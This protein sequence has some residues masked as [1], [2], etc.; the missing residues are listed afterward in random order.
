MLILS[1][2][3]CLVAPPVNRAPGVEINVQSLKDHLPTRYLSRL[4]EI[5]AVAYWLVPAASFVG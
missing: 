5:G 2:C 1:A 4:F 3:L